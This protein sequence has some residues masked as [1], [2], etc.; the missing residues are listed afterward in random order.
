MCVQFTE[1]KESL[2]KD[3]QSETLRPGNAWERSPTDMVGHDLI[4]VDVNIL[5]MA[6]IFFIL[7]NFQFF[8]H[9]NFYQTDLI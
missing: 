2:Q 4:C 5:N 9:K 1:T 7:K 8:F 3:R 6:P